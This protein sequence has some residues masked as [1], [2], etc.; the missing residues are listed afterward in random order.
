MDNFN[1]NLA[2]Q[3]HGQSSNQYIEQ[4]QGSNQ[5]KFDNQNPS[6]SN[7]GYRNQRNRY[8]FNRVGN[9]Y[10][11]GN[12]NNGNLSNG[13]HEANKIPIK[14]QHIQKS[15]PRNSINMGSSNQSTENK[16]MDTR[17]KDGAL[18]ELRTKIEMVD[19]TPILKVGGDY[20]LEED[21]KKNTFYHGYEDDYVHIDSLSQYD[22]RRGYRRKYSSDKSYPAIFIEK[23]NKEVGTILLECY[24]S[25]QS[26]LSSLT[27][28]SYLNIVTDDK[29][30][31]IKEIFRGCSIVELH[32]MNILGELIKALGVMPRYYWK[33]KHS[34]EMWSGS[35]VSPNYDINTSL[36]QAVNQEKLLINKYES[37][38]EQIDIANVKEIL[39]RI[40]LDEQVHVRLL[41]DMIKKYV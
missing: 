23:E 28:Y 21:N 19:G 22:R 16:A 8:G 40:I 31:E 4:G 2:K 10:S 7:N 18:E 35:Y 36:K 39:R 6:L 27:S 1:D 38:I 32:H 20:E 5:A 13:N 12:Q 11:N 37:L 41:E 9:M 30:T 33:N 29:Y 25:E 14:E 24:A 34:I 15:D 26:E 17:K 3:M